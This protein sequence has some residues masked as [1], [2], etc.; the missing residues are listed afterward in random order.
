MQPSTSEYAPGCTG[1]VLS[2]F[3]KEKLRDVDVLSFGLFLQK[4]RVYYS[5]S[6]WIVCCLEQGRFADAFE[7]YL[8]GVLNN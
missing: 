4:H 6:C 1:G 5:G 2:N 8:V 7:K 3:E